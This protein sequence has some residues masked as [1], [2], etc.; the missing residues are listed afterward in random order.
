VEK[1]EN[2]LRFDRIMAMSLWPHFLAHP[3]CCYKLDAVTPGGA[4]D[5]MRGR[6]FSSRSTWSPDLLQWE[7]GLHS[8]VIP[9]KLSGLESTKT[10]FIKFICRT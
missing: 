4:Y 6:S 7:V 2:L 8:L 1:V 3:V 10:S 9:T 5:G